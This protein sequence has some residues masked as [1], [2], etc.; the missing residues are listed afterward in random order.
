[1][2]TVSLRNGLSFTEEELDKITWM[3]P[4]RDCVLCNGTGNYP[5][6]PPTLSFYFP[7]PYCTYEAKRGGSFL[8]HHFNL[9][10]DATDLVM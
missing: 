10:I 6:P 1:M 2:K 7:C 4:L 9:P 8:Y 5:N 3:L